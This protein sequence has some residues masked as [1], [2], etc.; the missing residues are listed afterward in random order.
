MGIITIPGPALSR[1]NIF[2]SRPNH[3]IR[4]DFVSHPAG[5][6]KKCQPLVC[7]TANE[8]KRNI[9]HQH[10]YL[11][12]KCLLYNLGL[13]QRK[14]FWNLKGHGR[15]FPSVDLIY[16]D[17]PARKTPGKEL[18]FLKASL[19]LDKCRLTNGSLD[20]LKSLLSSRQQQHFNKNYPIEWQLLTLKRK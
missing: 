16:A 1:L 8:F 14:R 11:L 2:L 12:L 7:T 3:V 15:P 18:C 9:W 4:S 20:N 19:C 13:T 10:A 6:P 5:F 17:H